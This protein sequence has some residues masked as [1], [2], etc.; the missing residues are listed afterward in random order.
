MRRKTDL[1]SC[2]RLASQNKPG[3]TPLC[4]APLPNCHLPRAWSARL[5]RYPALLVDCPGRAAT[6]RTFTLSPSAKHSA[7]RR[8][9]VVGATGS[10]SSPHITLG[11]VRFTFAGI[12]VISSLESSTWLTETSLLL[13]DANCG[14]RRTCPRLM[15]RSSP[16]SLRRARSVARAVFLQNPS[17][18]S[19]FFTACFTTPTHLV[20]L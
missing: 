3:L 10:P 15:V 1:V 5:H 11:R 2:I 20:V 17:R 13:R 12:S 19:F 8:T 7:S 6:S 9:V 14:I 4:G 16:S 18:E